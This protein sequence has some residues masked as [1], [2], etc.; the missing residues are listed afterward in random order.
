MFVCV[1][2]CV[3]ELQLCGNYKFLEIIYLVGVSPV[4]VLSGEELYQWDVDG[5]RDKGNAY[6]IHSNKGKITFWW[7]SW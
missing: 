2:V 1:C 7:Q 6:C 3:C 5:K 4:V